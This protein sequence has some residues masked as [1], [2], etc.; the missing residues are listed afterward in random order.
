MLVHDLLARAAS[1][2]PDGIAV[3]DHSRP[4]TYESVYAAAVRAASAL[5]AHGVRR[6]D[7]VI[8]AIENSHTWIAAY[9]GILMTGAVAVPLPQGPRSDRFAHALTDCAPRACVTDEPTAAAFDGAARKSSLEARF[10]ISST[11]PRSSPSGWL[12]WEEV[13]RVAP[14]FSPHGP[15]I[16]LDSAA[17]IYTSGSTGRPRGVVLS[18]LNICANTASIVSYLGLQGNDRVMVVLPFYYVYGLSL[19]HTHVHVG[20]SVVIDN[21]FA[22]PNVVLSS[23]QAHEVTGF[24]GV[25]STFALLLHKSA[26][27]RMPLPSLQYVT[28]AGGPMSPTLIDQWRRVVPTARFYVMY[29][30]TEASARLS[31]LEPDQLDRR[32]GSIGRAIP[33][34]ELRLLREDGAE[35]APGEIGEIV[36]RGSNI[37]SGYWGAPEETRQAFGPEGYHTGDLARAD[38]DDFLYIVGRKSDMLK[39]GAHRVGTKEIEE[40]LHEHEAVHEAAV[41]GEAH[42]LL[43]EVPVA[44][45][46]FRDGRYASERDLIDHCRTR[47]A[48]YKV[49]TRLVVRDELPKSGAGKVDKRQLRQWLEAPEFS[50]PTGESDGRGRLDR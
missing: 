5:A 49:P 26:I 34:V 47:L 43:G 37:S 22:F 1:A 33:N 38:A 17:I 24:A 36:A 29:G 3:V 25:P 42:P 19:L 27:T 39:V 41:I 10:V 50:G 9:F 7:R 14:P 32:R 13:C 8:L 4:A 23:M 18:H 6:G 21:R 45:V 16:D 48:D 30:A 44:F 2:N 31:Y 46:A 40:T 35:A 11:G 15:L 12:D 28:Q 20:G